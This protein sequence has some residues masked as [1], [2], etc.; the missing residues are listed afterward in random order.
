MDAGVVC[1]PLSER[2]GDRAAELCNGGNTCP[3]DDYTGDGV[4]IGPEIFDDT[5]ENAGWD[6]HPDWTESTLALNSPG[7]GP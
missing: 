7:S 4:V 2:C 5:F 1:R 6:P 3:L